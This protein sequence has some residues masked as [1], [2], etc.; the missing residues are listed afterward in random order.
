MTRFHVPA[1]VAAILGAIATVL[2]LVEPTLSSPWREIA[3]AAIA[4]ATWA[5]AYVANQTVKTALATP[6]GVAVAGGAPVA[7]PAIT[8]E[9]PDVK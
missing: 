9:A 8:G 3:G 4:V 2:A 5:G 7:G 1:G 6:P